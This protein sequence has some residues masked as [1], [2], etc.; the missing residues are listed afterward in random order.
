MI[1]V[2]QQVLVCIQLVLQGRKGLSTNL[3]INIYIYNVCATFVH[4]IG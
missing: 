2:T 3:Y 4:M 1:C